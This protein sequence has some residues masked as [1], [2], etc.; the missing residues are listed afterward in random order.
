MSDL[1]TI[2]RE[3]AKQAEELPSVPD[4]VKAELYQ[5]LIRYTKTLVGGAED[6]RDSRRRFS[7]AIFILLVCWL[8]AVLAIVVLARAGSLALSN[9]VLIALVSGSVLQVIGLFAA[10]TKYLFR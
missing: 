4:D 8:V 3:N 9:E 2:M 5:Q 1:L 6:D 7:W 10:V